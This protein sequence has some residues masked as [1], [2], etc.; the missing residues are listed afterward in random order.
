M[1]RLTIAKAFTLAA[2]PIIFAQ[3]SATATPVV[4]F[5]ANP[6]PAA[7]NDLIFFDPS[8]SFDSDPARSLVSYSFDFGDGGGI[9]VA[10][11]P[12]SV[13][14]AYSLFG[15]Y[16]A[17]LSVTNDLNVVGQSVRTINV[18]QGNHSPIANA[19]GPYSI[20]SGS[21]LTFAGSANDPDFAAGD[22]IT[23]AAWDINNDGTFGDVTGL[24]PS[25]S[26]ALLHA[27]GIPLTPGGP[28][29]MTLRVTD[30]F[31][32]TNVSATTLTIESQA[33]P[34]PEPATLTILGAGVLGLTLVRRKRTFRQPMGLN[35]TTG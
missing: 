35:Q 1:P 22:S 13:S 11:S 15:S 24:T 19:G 7:P 26:A 28:Y 29:T 17:I 2:L 18:N 23:S 25:I 30:T 3:V 5:T 9:Y 21:G 8:A 33:I 4:S 14:H 20:G 31:G 32:A 10:A 12:D 34:A 16:T 6:N 27:L